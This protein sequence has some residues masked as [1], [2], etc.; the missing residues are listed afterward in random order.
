[1]GHDDIIYGYIHNKEGDYVQV[2]LKNNFKNIANFIAKC[3]PLTTI[4]ITDVLDTFILS[5]MGNFLDRIRDNDLEF[6]NDL[7]KELIP[8]Q[9]GEV[10]PSPIEFIIDTDEDGEPVCT[11]DEFIEYVRENTSYDLVN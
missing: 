5:T 6:R 7:L 10:E 4:V 11:R 9:M 8:L 2:K 3:P 1:M